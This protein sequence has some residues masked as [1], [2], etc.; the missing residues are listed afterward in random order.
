MKTSK[1]TP[2][3]ASI[4]TRR[5]TYHRNLRLSRGSC[6]A[7]HIMHDQAAPQPRSWKF[8]R[9]ASLFTWNVHTE[10]DDWRTTSSTDNQTLSLKWCLFEFVP[11]LNWNIGQCMYPH[12]HN[13]KG[14]HFLLKHVLSIVDTFLCEKLHLPDW[15][16]A[17]SRLFQPFSLELRLWEFNPLLNWSLDVSW[18]TQGETTIFP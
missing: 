3:K 12:L 1:Y 5:S 6:F 7:R 18:L 14:Q 8:M 13:W 11:L 2:C 9:G 16:T 15:A 17:F 4:S 10:L